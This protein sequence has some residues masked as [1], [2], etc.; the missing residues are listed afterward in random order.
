MEK[1]TGMGEPA[2]RGTEKGGGRSKSTARAIYS[3]KLSFPGVLVN[4]ADS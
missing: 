4:L 3:L 1:A 2:N